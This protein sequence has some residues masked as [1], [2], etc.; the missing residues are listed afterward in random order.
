MYYLALYRKSLPTPALEE[1]DV[2]SAQGHYKAG[3]HPPDFSIAPSISLTLPEALEWRDRKGNF[4]IPPFTAGAAEDQPHLGTHA[5]VANQWEHSIKPVLTLSTPWCQDWSGT[6]D[7][8]T[9]TQPSHVRWGHHTRGVQLGR[10][11]RGLLGPKTKET[12]G[13][14]GE[15]SYPQTRSEP[16]SPV[17]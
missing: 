10:W 12:S 16:P 11:G 6:T 13:A 5:M 2:T 9:H 3:W 4:T 15:V 8:H 1:G 14:A 17:L 7:T